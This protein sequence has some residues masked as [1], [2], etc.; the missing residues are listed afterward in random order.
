VTL[1]GSYNTI[2]YNACHLKGRDA[3]TEVKGEGWGPRVYFM[4][5]EFVCSADKGVQD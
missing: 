5:N 2:Q 4:E 3:G 1:T